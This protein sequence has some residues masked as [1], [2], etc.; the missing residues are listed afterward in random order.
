[1]VNNWLSYNG[2]AMDTQ[3]AFLCGATPK[4]HL[5]SAARGRNLIQVLNPR[6]IGDPESPRSLAMLG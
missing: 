5:L 4:H 6:P 2:Q 1:M 3:V